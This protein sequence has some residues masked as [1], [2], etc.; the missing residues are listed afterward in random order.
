MPRMIAMIWTIAAAAWI[1]AAPA[2]AQST[3]LASSCEASC[4]NNVSVCLKYLE[5]CHQ[6][7]SGCEDRRAQCMDTQLCMRTCR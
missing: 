4:Q 1:A 5:A 7:G 3:R 6:P 2:Q